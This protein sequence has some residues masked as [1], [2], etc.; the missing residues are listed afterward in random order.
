MLSTSEL[1]SMRATIGQALPDTCVIRRNT[2]VSDGG[3]GT[4]D[5]WSNL[6]TNVPCGIAPVA[7]GEA[8]N[9]INAEAGGRI[10]DESTAIVTLPAGQNITEADR[11]VIGDQTFEVTLVRE[12]AAWEISRRVEVKEAT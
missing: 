2:P 9:R 5:D 7:G 4:T 10:K 11:I 8:P 6:A 3:G 1:A 12:R